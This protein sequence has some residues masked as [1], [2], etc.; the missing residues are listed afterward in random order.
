MSGSKPVAEDVRYIRNLLEQQPGT[1]A[2]ILLMWAVIG[3]AGFALVD[4][5][6]A[7]VPWYWLA[8]APLG[9]IVSVLLGRRAAQRRGHIDPATGFRWT[10]H[11]AG[12]LVA[13]G[14]VVLLAALRIVPF[15]AINS[16]ALL[17]IA[18]AY[19]LAGIHLDRRLLWVAGALVAGFPAIILLPRFGWTAAGGLVAIA[20]VG[21]AL[22]GKRKGHG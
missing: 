19:F 10:W 18:A 15:E 16:L 17:L 21:V 20:L 3:A 12:L 13:V 9:M 4:L 1:P 22:T 5:A 8:A 14:A 2:S 7:A 6:P 11:W